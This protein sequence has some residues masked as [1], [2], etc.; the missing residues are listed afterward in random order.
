MNVEQATILFL[1]AVFITAE[2]RR[3]GRGLTGTIE[4]LDDQT[5]G[6]AD[7]SAMKVSVRLADGR[8]ILADLDSCTAC[9]ARLNIGDE[10]RVSNTKSGWVIGVPW[11]SRRGC[12]NRAAGC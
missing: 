1:I 2:A 5:L 12:G 4:G 3:M 7:F 6:L 9:M 11:M 10:V 8:L